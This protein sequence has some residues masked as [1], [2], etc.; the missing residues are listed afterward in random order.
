MNTA[1]PIDYTRSFAD[2]VR[3]QLYA[4]FRLGPDGTPEFEEDEDGLRH[5]TIDVYLRSPRA[6]E[7]YEVK[8]VMDDPT[9][10][11]PVGYSADATN[12]FHEVIQSYGEV[13][14]VVTVQIGGRVYEQRA[15][16]SQMLTNGHGAGTTPVI[17]DAIERI[18]KN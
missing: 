16:L 5:Y 14:V 17:R 13:P 10:Y 9:Y 18:K 2:N 8:Y 12:D 7:I 3:G 15:W 11:D 1:D 6:D 4:R